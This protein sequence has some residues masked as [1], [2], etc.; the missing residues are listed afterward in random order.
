[1]ANDTQIN[2]RR[3]AKMDSDGIFQ[4]MLP[5]ELLVYYLRQEKGGLQVDGRRSFPYHVNIIN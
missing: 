3:I 1:M 4:L 5:G 2:E